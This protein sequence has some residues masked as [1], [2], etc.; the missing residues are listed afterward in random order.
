MG[1]AGDAKIPG[2][3]LGDYDVQA[4]L[5]ESS[6]GEGALGSS[7][8]WEFDVRLSRQGSAVYWLNGQEAISGGIAA[9]G[10]SFTINT[11]VKVP[12]RAA[13]KGRLACNM[14][15]SDLT[16]GKFLGQGT[17]IPGFSGTLQF[18]YAPEANSDCTDL[19]GVEGGFAG[20][21]CEMSYVYEA[22]RR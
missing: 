9:D 5:Q 3:L 15:R 2:E 21:P 8:T 12:M 22:V 14:W 18:A 17:D 11:T 7:D 10:V 19:I 16:S 6:C 1:K 13:A 4:Q 20:L